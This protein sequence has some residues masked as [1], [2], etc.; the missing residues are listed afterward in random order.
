MPD[1]I[2][3]ATEDLRLSED[4]Y[5]ASLTFSLVVR[6]AS[7]LSGYT[8]LDIECDSEENYCLLFSG[9]QLLHDEAAHRQA[10]N[11]LKA[12]EK[13]RQRYEVAKKVWG[14]SA[15]A[16]LHPEPAPA[17]LD[18]VSALFEQP[19]RYYAASSSG[20][21]NGYPPTY[22]TSEHTGGSKGMASL[23]GGVSAASIKKKA[24]L[25]PAQ[26]L[27]WKAPGTQIWARLK[28]AGL[29]VKVVFSWDLRRVILKIRCVRKSG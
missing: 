14:E 6:V 24:Y 23:A 9:F 22:S 8:T 29:Q 7:A 28:M 11:M 3:P 15:R 27:G 5:V 20:S 18:P 13:D 26:F 17:L 12:S 1:D 2:V 19:S 21:G 25:P 16:L 10:Q 4:L